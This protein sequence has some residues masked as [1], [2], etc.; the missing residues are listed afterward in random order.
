MEMT[1]IITIVPESYC[2]DPLANG[3]EF[4]DDFFVI[5][6]EVKQQLREGF[7]VISERLLEAA[8]EHIVL[9]RS[10]VTL[11]ATLCGDTIGTSV[12]AHPPSGTYPPA[13]AG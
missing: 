3:Q 13:A 2:R 7:E 12:A 6:N 8:A 11:R 1:L 4:T 9:G 10:D 5:K